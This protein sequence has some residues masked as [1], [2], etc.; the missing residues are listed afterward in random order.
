M[1]AVS[2]DNG[3]FTLAWWHFRLAC[4]RLEKAKSSLTKFATV[5]LLLGTFAEAAVAES[6]ILRQLRAMDQRLER[7]GA[8]KYSRSLR[9]ERLF[10]PPTNAPAGTIFFKPKSKTI[11]SLVTIAFH[12]ASRL[13]NEETKSPKGNAQ[14]CF[15][16]RYHYRLFG[17]DG[18]KVASAFLLSK[19]SDEF[20]TTARMTSLYPGAMFYQ[21]RGLSYFT[22][23]MRIS[24]KNQVETRV[25]GVKVLADLL[26]QYDYLASRVRLFAADGRTVLKQIDNSKPEKLASGVWVATV[27]H[28]R[29]FGEKKQVVSDT[30]TRLLR[31]LPI[32]TSNVCQMKIPT[33][34]V[35]E[36]EI[37]GGKKVTFLKKSAENYTAD[38]LIALAIKRDVQQT[39]MGAVMNAKMA[40]RERQARTRQILQTISLGSALFGVLGIAFLGVRRLRK[41]AG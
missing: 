26:P 9:D 8:F 1:A 29:L 28:S 39:K 24:A 25:G 38:Q 12:G 30:Q 17:G 15:D 7:A 4:H 41:K 19:K 40:E 2:N 21:G 16:G 5:T 3:S 11:D 10:E 35:V 13:K 31:E 6:D 20:D 34:T 32:P 14:Q 36:V 23:D 37:A 33:N 18:G 27:S 22:K